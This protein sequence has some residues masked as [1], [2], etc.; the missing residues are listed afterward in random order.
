MRLSIVLSLALLP[1]SAMALDAENMSP[2]VR[3][4]YQ[5]MMQQSANYGKRTE[6][7]DEAIEAARSACQQQR[8]DLRIDIAAEHAA[9]EIMK[10]RQPSEYQVNRLAS[11][12]LSKIDERFRPDLT[13]SALDAK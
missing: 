13:R 11:S 10:G 9:D 8:E 12:V 7:A 6:R 5:C 4:Y 2:L 3:T 1:I